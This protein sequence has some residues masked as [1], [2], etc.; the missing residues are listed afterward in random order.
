MNMQCAETYFQVSKADSDCG[1]T[2]RLAITQQNWPRI[3]GSSQSAGL[4]G[5][6]LV[7]QTRGWP[8]WPEARD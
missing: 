8:M 2:D 3:F 7:K 4:L 5:M 1:S 6:L